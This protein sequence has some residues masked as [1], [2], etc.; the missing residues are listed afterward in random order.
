M[1]KIETFESEQH[2]NTVQIIK[3]SLLEF[4]GE[5]N[6]LETRIISNQVFQDSN[7]NP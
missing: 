3:N 5:L 2:L 1:K 6:F 4:S 7:L